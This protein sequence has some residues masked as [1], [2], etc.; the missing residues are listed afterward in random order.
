M[1]PEGALGSVIPACKVTLTRLDMRATVGLT[2]SCCRALRNSIA[3][4]SMEVQIRFTPYAFSFRIAP[5]KLAT[6]FPLQVP[7][8]DGVM[9]ISY[10]KE[11]VAPPFVSSKTASTLP[12]GDFIR[13]TSSREVQPNVMN[14]SI[15]NSSRFIHLAFIRFCW[16]NSSLTSARVLMNR[17]STQIC[18]LICAQ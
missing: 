13:A 4:S 5:Y 15:V 11:V 12:S 1:P 18:H 17:C 7:D 3:N 9:N 2:S 16:L 8:P 14:M 10:P 6:S